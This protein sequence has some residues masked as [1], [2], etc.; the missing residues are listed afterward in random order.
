[1][2]I[3]SWFKQLKYY[4]FKPKP[5]WDRSTISGSSVHHPCLPHPSS[6]RR[7]S[8][9]AGMF[10]RDIIYTSVL[11]SKT[12]KLTENYLFLSMCPGLSLTSIWAQWHSLVTTQG[13]AAVV[14]V[15][16]CRWDVIWVV[17]GGWCWP[18]CSKKAE[19]FHELVVLRCLFGYKMSGG[20]LIH[21]Y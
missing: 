16:P 20:E 18:F 3:F 10:K 12:L 7:G 13:S 4:K 6:G 19:I 15:V 17:T 1:M 9:T 14:E 11:K 21:T 2:N 8:H 5:K